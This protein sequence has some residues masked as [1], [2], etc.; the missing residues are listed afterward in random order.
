MKSEITYVIRLV[1]NSNEGFPV[2]TVAIAPARFTRSEILGLQHVVTSE[3]E[4]LFVMFSV[5]QI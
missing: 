3:V 4:E 1:L 2:E 5:F